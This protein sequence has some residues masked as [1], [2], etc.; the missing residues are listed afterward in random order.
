MSSAKL[1]SYTTSVPAARSIGEIQGLL[2]EFGATDIALSAEEGRVVG[3]S[4]AMPFKGK[5]IP[6]RLPANIEK[7][8]EYLWREYQDNTTRGRKKK[9]DFRE[10]AQNIG[11]RIVKEWVHAQLSII[12]VEMV[13]AVEVFLGYLMIDMEQKTTLADQFMAG[14]L[15][16]MIPEITT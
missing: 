4:F 12:K 11:W 7:V 1:K 10:D 8:H 14:K 6:F 13:E 3:I 15:N 9:D 5:K 2:L 16:R